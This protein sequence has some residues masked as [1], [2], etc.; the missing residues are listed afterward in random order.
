[1]SAEAQVR[2]YSEGYQR[3]F[4][5]RQEAEE[6]LSDSAG[7][8]YPFYDVECTTRSH[9]IFPRCDPP[10]DLEALYV[11]RCDG[12]SRGNPGPSGCG[13]CI[14]SLR[15]RG[16]DAYGFERYKEAL[17]AHYMHD[18]GHGTNNVAEYRGL[19]RGLILALGL[20]IRCI[21]VEMDSQLVLNQSCGVWKTRSPTMAFHRDSVQALLHEF[22]WWELQHIYSEHNGRADE[23]ANDAIDDEV[24]GLVCLHENCMADAE[25]Y[26]DRVR[27]RFE[28]YRVRVDVEL[29]Y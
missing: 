20:G 13:G 2:G 28:Q 21:R 14:W 4:Y 27:S 22:D 19:A 5:S 15:D 16:Q 26:V 17:M 9:R 10:D 3:R 24:D 23:L 1:M 18:C 8:R 6:W 7:C 29:C 11:L 25:D 12:A